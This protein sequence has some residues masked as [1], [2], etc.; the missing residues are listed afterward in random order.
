MLSRLGEPAGRRAFG[1]WWAGICI[2]GALLSRLIFG[3]GHGFFITAIWLLCVFAPVRI[4]IEVLHT[5][6][7]RIRRDLLRSIERRDDRYTTREGA[8]LMVESLFA[9]EVRLPRLAP[10]DLGP[11]VIEAATRVSE[12][13][14]RDEGPSGVLEA[15]STCA[16]LLYRWIGAVVAGE[17]MP[18]G[19][20]TEGRRPWETNGAAP[21]TLWNPQAS[22]QEQWVSLRAITG[23]AALAKTLIAVFEDIA[24]RSWEGGARVRALAEAAMDYAD[25]VG[26]RLDGPAWEEIAAVPAPDLTPDRLNQLA[27]AWLTFCATPPPAP[28]RLQAFVDALAA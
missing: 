14:L 12:R 16:A 9:R 23:M 10:P 8:T 24:G 13:A 22:V 5:K 19:D 21:A 28:R 27:G 20:P 17:V 15:G 18:P 7:P 26:L 6:G 2:A 25:Q 1:R 3:G 11:K 4:A